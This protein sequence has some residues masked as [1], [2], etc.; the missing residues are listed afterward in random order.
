MGTPANTTGAYAEFDT[1]ENA[2]NAFAI[3]ETWADMATDGKLTGEDEG[4]YE[5]CDIDIKKEAILFAAFSD[6]TANLGWQCE[7]IVEFLKKQPGC[8]KIEIPIMIQ[9]KGIFWEKD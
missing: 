5:I 6:K 8:K 9:G 1:K 2:K 3:F 4:D 7:R